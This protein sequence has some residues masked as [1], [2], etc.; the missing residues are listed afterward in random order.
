MKFGGL[1]GRKKNPE[2]IIHPF[3]LSDPKGTNTLARPFPFFSL[4][5]YLVVHLPSKSRLK[6]RCH[7]IHQP[8]YSEGF[9]PSPAGVSSSFFS[10]PAA[11]LASGAVSAS[12][13]VQR[14]YRK[15]H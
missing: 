12:E 14:V 9:S 2:C 6:L 13:E 7:S 3:K 1:G 8:L 15:K 11:P 10:P 5:L 4:I